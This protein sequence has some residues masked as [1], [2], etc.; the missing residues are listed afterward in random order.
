MRRSASRSSRIEA[1]VPRGQGHAAAPCGESN[2]LN[3]TKQGSTHMFCFT[4]PSSV[5]TSDKEK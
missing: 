5:I 2:Q 3:R 1:P 4:I